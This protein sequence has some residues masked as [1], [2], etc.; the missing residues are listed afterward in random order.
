MKMNTRAFSNAATKLSRTFGKVG[1]FAKKHAPE[2]LIV[3]GT[4]SMI[5]GTV[6]AC[7][8][9]V[10]A[11]DVLAELNADME[12]VRE[13]HEKVEN[14]EVP[15]EK[16]PPMAYKKEVVTTYAKYGL[17]FAKL[18][19]PSIILTGLG[20]FSIFASNN[21]M[22]KRCASLSAAYVT[23]D[24]MFKRYRKNV[25][26]KYGEEVDHEMRYG[27]KKEKIEVEE[28]DP[29]T[30]KIKKVKKEV[31]VMSKDVPDGFSD[32]ARFWDES[33]DGFYTDESGRPN[34]DCNLYY[35]KAREKE[36]N[37]RLRSQGYL[38]LNDVY[39]MLGIQPSI[40]GQSVGWVYDKTKDEQDQEGD[41]FISFQINK[42]TVANAR[43]IEG[44]EDVILLDFNVDGPILDR[45]KG[46]L[47]RV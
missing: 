44:I 3:S 39:K 47:A 15:E 8:A 41:G 7:K 36:A 17:Q 29:E 4:A 30:G 35:L 9:T 6:A 33:C 2:I 16:Y 37:I 14:G 32:Y 12:P 40:A 19:A 10:K 22:R 20:I 46:T 28:T 27:I 42:A 38:F 11:A 26:D 18:Y 25:V 31:D 24:Q 45:L 34:T 23:L 43:F 13:L 1:L 5:A 21:I